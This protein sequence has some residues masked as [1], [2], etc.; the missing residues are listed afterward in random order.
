MLTK[1]VIEE[2]MD[3]DLNN[4]IDKAKEIPLSKIPNFVKKKIDEK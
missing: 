3:E 2:N 1:K 4:I